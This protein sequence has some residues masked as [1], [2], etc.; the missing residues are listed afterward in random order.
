M[1][2]PLPSPALCPSASGGPYL[3]THPG[4]SPQLGA[5]SPALWPPQGEGLRSNSPSPSPSPLW[6][7]PTRQLS[8]E[9]VPCFCNCCL[10][11]RSPGLGPRGEGAGGGGIQTCILATQLTPECTHPLPSLGGWRKAPTTTVQARSPHSGTWGKERP[12]RFPATH[13]SNPLASPPPI[14]RILLFHHHG[15]T[16]PLP[17]SSHNPSPFFSPPLLPPSVPL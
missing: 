17:H 3:L 4:C 11:S 1:A 16:T 12:L 10:G 7:L 5:P 14:P 2:R 9:L 8:G 6:P 15:W 13:F